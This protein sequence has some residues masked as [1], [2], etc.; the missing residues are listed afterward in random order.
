MKIE[1]GD[2]VCFFP[3]GQRLMKKGQVIRFEN[4]EADVWCVS[5]QT[6]YRVKIANLKKI[7]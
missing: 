5:E 2:V 6:I 7:P 3:V 4:D 1:I